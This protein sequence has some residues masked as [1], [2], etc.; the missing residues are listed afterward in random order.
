MKLDVFP[1]LPS[2]ALA[3]WWRAGEWRW[4]RLS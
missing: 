4:R 2:T 1:S 3:V